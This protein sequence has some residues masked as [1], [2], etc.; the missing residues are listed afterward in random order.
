VILL[1][2][3]MDTDYLGAFKIIAGWWGHQP[4]AVSSPPTWSAMRQF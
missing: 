2:G 1:K 4:G 3:E